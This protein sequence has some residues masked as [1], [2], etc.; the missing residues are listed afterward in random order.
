MAWVGFWYAALT[1]ALSRREREPALPASPLAAYPS[2]ASG[3]S[4]DELSSAC[5]RDEGSRVGEGLRVRGRPPAI[6][7]RVRHGTIDCS[8]AC[9]TV[10]LCTARGA[11]ALRDHA[12]RNGSA[13]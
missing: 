5:A 6:Y 4:D 13:V 1:P 12:S 7:L 2:R 8:F 9:G 3:S 11:G 10:G